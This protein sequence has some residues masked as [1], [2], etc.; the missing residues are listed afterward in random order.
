MASKRYYRRAI[1]YILVVANLLQAFAFYL[2]F[3]YLP[4]F[5]TDIGHSTGTAAMVLSVANLAQVFGEI[6]FGQLSDKV[7]VKFL[8]IIS[9]ASASLSALLLWGLLGSRSLAALITFAFLFGSFGSGFLALWARM[10]TLFGDKD[11]PMV[12]STMCFG[13]GI[14]S[15][16]SGPI[17]SALLSL[18]RLEGAVFGAGKYAPIIWFV[19]SCMAGS[20]IVGGLGILALA[21]KDG[22]HASKEKDLDSKRSS[23]YM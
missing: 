20:A 10:G 19:G 7:H 15:I 2:P 5:T 18:A 6:G 21:W 22:H 17:S 23:A 12:Y 3:I 11:A 13:R 1:F 4:S 14:G 16:L 9:T 8:V